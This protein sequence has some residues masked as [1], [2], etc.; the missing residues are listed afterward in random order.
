MKSKKHFPVS[1]SITKD[2]RILLQS[3]LNEEQQE[4]FQLSPGDRYLESCKLWTT[5]K[6]FGGRLEPEPDSQSPFDFPE[7]RSKIP[8]YGRAGVHFIRRS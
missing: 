7:M 4:W 3:I 2:L 1:Q 8:A 5:Y 6:K